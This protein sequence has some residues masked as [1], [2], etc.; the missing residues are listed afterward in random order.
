MA[1]KC[2][3]PD[4]TLS[5]MCTGACAKE[6]IVKHVDEVKRD[7]MNGFAELIMSQVEAMIRNRMTTLQVTFQKEQFDTYKKA[8]I[9]GIH[10]GI[11]IGKR[12]IR[13]DY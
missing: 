3:N 12:L 5:Q 11:A 9:E 13:D 2:T 7:P 4:G 8:Y 10:E 1:C 6:V